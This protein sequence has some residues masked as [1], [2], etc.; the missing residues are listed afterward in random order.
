[1]ILTNSDEGCFYSI[2][3]QIPG[4]KGIGLTPHS[5]RKLFATK[6][7]TSGMTLPDVCNVMGWSSMQTAMSYLQVSNETKLEDQIKR[8]TCGWG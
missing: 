2:G 1:L 6:L 8:A 5:L 3:R 4:P 7:V